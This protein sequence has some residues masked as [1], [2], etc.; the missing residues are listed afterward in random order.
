V[1]GGDAEL[2]GGEEGEGGG[3]G[4]GGQSASSRGHASSRSSSFESS[5]ADLDL[6]QPDAIIFSVYFVVVFFFFV[7]S[8]RLVYALLFI[9]LSPP[10]ACFMYAPAPSLPLAL[11]QTHART[12]ARTHA[13]TRTHACLHAYSRASH[14]W[15]QEAKP[16]MT[17]MQTFRMLSPRLRG[18][19]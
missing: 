15:E 3:Q 2:C 18:T 10:V 17:N 19:K 1:V 12:H 7:V 11:S 4:R 9:Y 5:G 16:Y 13:H 14:R 8:T 6:A